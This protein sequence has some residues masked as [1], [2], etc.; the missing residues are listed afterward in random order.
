MQ[1]IPEYQ[2][3][4]LQIAPEAPLRLRGAM[5]GL[6]LQSRGAVRSDAVP[7]RRARRLQRLGGRGGLGCSV[8][9]GAEA[10]VHQGL[11]TEPTPLTRPR[12]IDVYRFLQVFY[13]FFRT[14]LRE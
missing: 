11:A 9:V 8:L 10:L 4:Y 6:P 7:L 5:G 1:S 3:I 13:R 14:F 12:R 2:Q